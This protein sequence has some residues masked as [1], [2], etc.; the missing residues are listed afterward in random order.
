MAVVPQGMTFLVVDVW[1]SG[2]ELGE[3]SCRL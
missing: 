2:H 1:A 3:G